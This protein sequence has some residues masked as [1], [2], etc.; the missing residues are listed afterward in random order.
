MGH[1][2]DL[3]QEHLSKC[4]N[5]FVCC[6][7]KKSGKVG[8]WQSHTCDARVQ[9]HQVERHKNE[10]EW[11]QVSCLYCKK[12]GSYRDI[13]EH[14]KQDCLEVLLTCSNE[15]CHEKVKRCLMTGHHKVV[16]SRLCLVNMV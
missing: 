12:V 7:I 11:R 3:D 2:K 4:P 13:S 8:Y 1:L 16:Q 5:E 10:C 9:R 6:D 15:G 14:Q